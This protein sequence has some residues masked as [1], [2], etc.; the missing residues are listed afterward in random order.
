MLSDA[1]YSPAGRSVASTYLARGACQERCFTRPLLRVAPWRM[2]ALN[3]PLTH[4]LRHDPVVPSRSCRTAARDHAL[5]R[6]AARPAGAP[7]SRVRHRRLLCRRHRR[8]RA[9]DDD[10]AKRTEWV[11]GCVCATYR[12]SSV[13]GTVVFVRLYLGIGRSWLMWLVI[14]LRRAFRSRTSLSSP[15]SISCASKASSA[16]SCWASGSRLLGARH[17]TMAMACIAASGLVGDLRARRRDYALAFRHARCATPGDHCG[18]QHLHVRH[19]LGP[20]EAARYLGPGSMADAHYAPFP[21]HAGPMAYEMSRD[22][23]ARRGSPATCAK[24]KSVSSW[25]RAPGDWACGPGTT[26]AAGSGLRTGRARCSVSP[27]ATRSA[28][29]ASPP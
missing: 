23:C 2:T 1:P 13:V 10:L 21:D 7:Q 4:E 24:A 22:I 18:R 12:F 27:T 28:L 19:V 3:R 16:C 6:V 5:A 25:P 14:A 11:S 15:T 20:A 8:D 17:P 26:S 29:I 9:R